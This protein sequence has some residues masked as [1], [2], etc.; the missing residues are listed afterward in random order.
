MIVY[1]LS[2]LSLQLVQFIWIAIRLSPTPLTAQS[3]KNRNES[4]IIQWLENKNALYGHL[5]FQVQ[6]GLPFISVPSR[7]PYNNGGL[8][9]R[10]CLGLLPQSL[11]QAGILPPETVEYVG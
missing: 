7:H 1:T 2:L 4:Q 3:K 10:I 9:P 11:C 6:V 5:C 8:F